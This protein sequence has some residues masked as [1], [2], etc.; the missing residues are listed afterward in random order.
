VIITKRVEGEVDYND[1]DF[2]EVNTIGVE[3]K[4]KDLGLG[5]L[6]IHREDT[7]DTPC[8]FRERF[9]AGTRL[10]VVITTTITTKLT[11]VTTRSTACNS[12]LS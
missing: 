3:G 8:E 10:D 1:G 9:S 11:N 4:E 5:T 12:D 2:A 7:Q 6:Q